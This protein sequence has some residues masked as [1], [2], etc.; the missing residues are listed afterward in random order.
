MK[1]AKSYLLAVMLMASA[2][3]PDVGEMRTMTA[4]PVTAG[5]TDRRQRR[6]L[7]IPEVRQKTAVTSRSH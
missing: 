7:R 5:R 6:P 4:A 1:K 2:V 3:L